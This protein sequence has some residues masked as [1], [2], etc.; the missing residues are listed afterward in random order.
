MIKETVSVECVVSSLQ[1]NCELFTLPLI[2]YWLSIYSACWRVHRS[3]YH[4]SVYRN[5]TWE[6]DPKIYGLV[7]AGSIRYIYCYI[8][9]SE[10]CINNTPTIQPHAQNYLSTMELRSVCPYKP[11]AFWVEHC[12]I[13]TSFS[14][15]RYDI[16]KERLVR[17][18]HSLHSSS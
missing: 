14:F 1:F 15:P 13:Q 18:L 6:Y 4:E 2:L 5:G 8:A 11:T 7:D 3:S 9:F 12:H 17:M 16:F 10:L